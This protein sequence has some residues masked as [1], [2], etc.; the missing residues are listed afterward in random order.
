MNE[1]G[2]RKEIIDKRLLEAGWNVDDVTQVIQEFDIEVTHEQQAAEP[3]PFYGHQFSDYVLLD[4]GGVPLAVVEAKKTSVDARKGEEQAKQYAYNIQKQYGCDLPFCIYTNGHDIYYWDL[5]NYPPRK[6]YGF[7]KKEDLERLAFIRK[8][9]NPLP[10]ELINTA[11]AGRPYQIEAIRKVMEA[12]E[13]KKRTFLLIMATGTGKTRTCIAMVEALMKAGWVSR[14]LFLVDRIAL[15]NQAVEAFQEHTPNLSVWPKYGEKEIATD[16]R[17]YVSTYPTMLNIID[18]DRSKLSPHF[19]DMII[20]DESHRSI[21]NVYQNVLNYFNAITLGLTATPTDAIDHNTFELFECE[22]GLPT[23][24]YTYEQAVENQPPYLTNFEVMSITTKFQQEGIHAQ[25]ISLEDQKKLMAE[26]KDPEEI[27]YEGTELERTVSNKGTN[28]LIVREFMEEC[29]KD[30]DGVLPG[31]TIFF[32]MTKKHARRVKDIFDQYYP[33]YAGELA[34]VIVSD[35]PRVYGKGGLLDQFKNNNM[36]R[37]A[38]SVDMLDTGID[39]REI[40][41]LVFMKPVFSYTK[42][43]QMIGRGTRVLEENKLKSW[44]HEKDKFLI[45]DCWDNFEYFKL[46]P[47]GREASAQLAL[48]IRL[49]KLRVEK[50]RIAS[51]LDQDIAVAESVEVRKLINLLPQA[52]VV[53]LDSKEALVKVNAD[54]FW[55]KINEEKLV[56]LEEI[57]APLMRAIGSVDFKAM[58][59]EK[60]VVETSI[61]KLKEEEEDFQNLQELLITQLAELPLTIDKVAKEKELINSALKTSYWQ[62]AKEKDFTV[63][64]E[65]L[66]PLMKYR[67][68]FAFADGEVNLN[69][70]DVTYSKKMIE[71]GPENERVSTSRYKEMVEQMVHDLASTNLLLQRLKNGEELTEAEVQ[72]LANLM[73]EKDPFVT[74]GLMQKVYDNSH[75][76]FIDFIEHILGIKEIQAF[77][78][79]VGEQFDA[80]I[81]VH[82]N[83][84]AMQLQ[85]IALLRRFISDKGSVEKK[86]LIRAPF[87]QVHPSGIIGI[88]TPKE[89][90][91]IID[92]TNKI[93]A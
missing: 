40:V 61:A 18:K 31:K 55:T 10:E 75:A 93:V 43:W 24:A 41:N 68:S 72:N 7:P 86:D 50:L 6:I 12:I 70:Q 66:A 59:F 32:C 69:L 44:C 23:F 33:Q 27:N 64:V 42:F 65:K 22:D 35:D 3:S 30:T 14:V 34:K 47:K 37:I 48:P 39:I 91:E 84:T 80:F 81:N 77:E 15:R 21:Y 90:N 85:F 17:V 51:E 26:G 46:K 13:A 52:N 38:I 16:R 54:D 9:R 76:K 57:I 63:L 92:L 1:A 20:V 71:F 28:A 11:I 87:T 88:F 29:I 89:I 67:R 53:I 5:E 25:N 83:L 4:K 8:N 62:K 74:E 73:S 78:V 56:Y 2:T 45:M 82:N 58:R 19:F 60:D 49:F 36:P 79:V